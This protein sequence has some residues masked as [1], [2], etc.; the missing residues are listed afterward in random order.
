LGNLPKG[1]LNLESG[2]EEFG[3]GKHGVLVHA[4]IAM[5]SRKENSPRI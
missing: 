1:V 3:M 2:I 5:K 4:K